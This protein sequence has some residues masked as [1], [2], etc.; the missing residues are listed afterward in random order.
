M[1]FN[2]VCWY[3]AN[4]QTSTIILFL[5]WITDVT[6]ETATVW[7]RYTTRLSIPHC[8]Y[9]TGNG[10]YPRASW[11]GDQD[12][13]TTKLSKILHKMRL[14]VNSTKHLNRCIPVIIR[15]RFTLGNLRITNYKFPNIRRHIPASGNLNM[16]PSVMIHTPFLSE[17]YLM[18][19][20]DV[21]METATVRIMHRKDLF[22]PLYIPWG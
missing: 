13:N 16:K 3:I 15:T 14:A 11:M 2:L 4:N 19:N 7:M 5:V 8:I 18:C 1:S 9:P 12:Q 22:T 17:L 6:M 10:L 20:E 21:A